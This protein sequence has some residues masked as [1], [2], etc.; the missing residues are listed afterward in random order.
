MS[1][2]LGAA[3]LHMSPQE[4]HALLWPVR[5]DL[6]AHAKRMRHMLERAEMSDADRASFEAAEQALLA[7]HAEIARIWKESGSR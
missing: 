1:K 6:E 2:P 5:K 4:A 3:R 7:A